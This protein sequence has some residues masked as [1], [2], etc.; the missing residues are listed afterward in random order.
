MNP[1]D[2]V[3]HL[4]P[5]HW[6]RA[7]RL[8]VRKALAEFAH[9]RLLDPRPMTPGW[10]AVASDDGATEYRFA[11]QRRALDHWHIDPDTITRRRDGVEQPLDLVDLV[12]DLRDALGI[13]ESVLPVYLEELTSTLAASAAR[14]A[15]PPV[16]A[17][18]LARADYQTI[19]AAMTEG[20]PCFVANSGRIGFDA[21]E[22]HAYAPEAARPLRLL[23]LAAAR[24]HSTF[25][26][27]A[28]LD[29]DTLIRAELDAATLGR[30]AAEMTRR[31]LDLA[32]YH[33]IPVHP[34]QWWNR[35]AVTFA[36]EVARQRL[37]CL[38]PGA[39]DYRAQQSIRTFF[40][41][42][43]PEKHYVKTALS[44]LNMGFLRG[45]SGEFISAAPP[46]NDWL[47][48]LVAGDPVLK[49][50]GLTILR[51]RAAVGY[52]H[53][54]YE[55][56]APSDSP[57]R[58]MLAALW[59]ESPA[60]LLGPGE[61][62]ATMAAL[63]HVDRDGVALVGELIAA[64][65]LPPAAWLRRYLD[66]YLTP[67]LHCFYAHHLVF[68]PHGENVILVLDDRGIPQRAI[69]KDIAE[70]IAVLDPDAELP[71]EVSRIQVKMPEE[72]RL[73]SI[74]TDVFDCF[75]RF[76]SALMHE[77][78]I[79]TETEFW[80]EV[81]GC[82]R[83]YQRANPQLADQF[84]RYDMFVGEFALSCL[85]RLQLRDNKQM[86]DLEDPAAS[87]QLVGTLVNPIAG[88]G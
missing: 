51:E 8:L 61:R 55:A 38:G 64:S 6:D 66:A 3:A 70:E 2:A 68:M 21:A 20:H 18:Q 7:N 59:R 32:D 26:G 41:I 35:L 1:S 29:Y 85:N 67:L 27:G 71:Q 78:G 45:L 36:G 46:I 72:M 52:R 88:L 57:Y 44:V 43:A 11:A 49:G 48:E 4:T 19:E 37:V 65:G 69:F 23:W 12:L 34:W 5:A 33:L 17:A 73:L 62:L 80:A 76:L 14:L 25:T 79:L 15:A 84:R 75:F 47:A 30:F 60:P 42:S 50:T 31:G 13:S 74:F 77:Q 24:E 56:G 81:A 58:K 63:L 40:N 16:P 9:E 28:G 54:Q 83:E 10:Y 53:A 87:L 82:V 39:D 86:V 22:Y